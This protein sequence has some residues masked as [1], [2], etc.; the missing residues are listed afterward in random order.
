M[1]AFLLLTRVPYCSLYEHG[2][3]S[4]GNVHNTRPNEALRI[5][6]GNVASQI[7]NGHDGFLKGDESGVQEILGKYRPAYDLLDGALERA[8]RTKT[9]P[10]KAVANKEAV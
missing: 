10:K 9:V 4:I 6:N 8:G 1:W 3:T 5:P 7:S 2:Y